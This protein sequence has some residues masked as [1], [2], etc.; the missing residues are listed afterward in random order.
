L[1]LDGPARDAEVHQVGSALHLP[2]LA[3]FF[4]RISTKTA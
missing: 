4:D 1:S 3:R 2:H